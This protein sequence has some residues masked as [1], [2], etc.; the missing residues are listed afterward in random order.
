MKKSLPI[1]LAQGPVVE[2]AIGD[3]NKAT[4]SSTTMQ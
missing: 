1:M 4:K 2:A 3:A